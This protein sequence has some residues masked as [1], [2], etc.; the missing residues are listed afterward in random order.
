MGPLCDARHRSFPPGPFEGA[1]RVLSTDVKQ[2]R[3]VGPSVDAPPS[4]AFRR[5]PRA[6]GLSQA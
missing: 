6:V 1:T 3:P 5:R 2:P 4:L